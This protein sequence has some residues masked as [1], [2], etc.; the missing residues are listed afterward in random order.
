MK[1]IETFINEIK[2]NETL[3]MQLAEAMKTN[4]L[5][6]FLK[7]QGCE[8]TEEEFISAI[9]E[10]SE[11]LSE[12]DLD[13]VAGGANWK[14]ALLSVFTIGVGCAAEA[15]QS[16]LHGDVGNGPDGEILCDDPGLRV[17]LF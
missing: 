17:G 2:T 15:I 8:A 12:D 11:E 10:P 4:T 14:E 6:N 13:A 1:T 5:A 16:S 7:A 9:K 3:Q